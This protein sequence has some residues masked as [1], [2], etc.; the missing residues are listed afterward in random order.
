[1]RHVILLA[2]LA[3]AAAA[4]RPAS[5]EVKIGFVNLRR[6][7]YEV[8]EGKA[9]VAQLKREEA[10]KQKKLDERKA[11]LTRLKGEYDKQA[12]VLSDKARAEKAGEIEQKLA[13]FQQ[14]GLQWE[15]ELNVK[16]QQLLG[17]VGE[18]LDP[19][20][21]EIA[22]A[23][24]LTFVLEKGA[25]LYGPSALDLTNEL[26]RKYN[27]RYAKKGASAPATPAAPKK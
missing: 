27:A 3:I 1:M 15:Q 5:A 16:Q 18:R 24:G 19:V 22:E 26:I 21:K 10:E 11:E 23:E 4:P 13:E 9:A 25:V 17:A 6:A 7:A 20:V 14:L 8:D 12:M 2:T